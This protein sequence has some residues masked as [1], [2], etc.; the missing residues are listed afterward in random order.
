M[1]NTVQRIELRNRKG[2]KIV[3]LLEF[4]IGTPTG[5]TI[6][7]HG[8]GGFKEQDHVVTMAKAFLNNGFVT[9]NFDATNTFGESDGEY[10]KATLGLHYEDFEDVANW[11]QEQDWFVA[12]LAVAGHSMGGYSAARYAEEYPDKIAFCAPIAPVVSGTLSWEAHEEFEPEEF[13]KWEETGMLVKTSSTNPN[14]IRRSPWTHMKERLDHDLLRKADRLVMPVFLYVGT[15]D[16]SIPPK[17]VQKFFDAIPEGKKTLVISE[18]APH[19]YRTEGELRDLYND[20][21]QWIKSF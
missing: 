12:P 11:A 15:K 2:Q 13:R 17:H 1:E 18:G 4:P 5:T 8:Y 10:E 14:N 16:T 7:Q 20:L 9:F 3:G 21:D 6:V 19:T